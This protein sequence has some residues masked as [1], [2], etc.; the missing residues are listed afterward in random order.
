MKRVCVLFGGISSESAISLA[1]GQAILKA[2]ER[3]GYDAVPIK[4]T[5]NLESCIQSLTNPR[6]DVA[7]IGLHGK[8]AEDGIIQGV[9]EYLK[10]PY[11]G[12]G[13][14]ASALAMN[15]LKAKE[16]FAL[17]GIPI[18]KHVVVRRGDHKLSLP[19]PVVVK[20]NIE[21]SS[22]GISVVESESDYKVALEEAFRF[23]DTVLVEEYIPGVEI[24]IPVYLGESLEGI[25]ISPKS[26]FYDYKN[27]YTSGATD[28]FIPP[29]VSEDI[30]DNLR[31]L[32]LRAFE[33]LGCRQYGRV[34]FRVNGDKPYVLEVNTLPGCTET[35]LVPKA[36][37]Y[38]GIGFDEF[39][40]SLIETAR[41]DY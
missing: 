7:V 10:I 5:E 40:K 2:V 28:Y 11:T 25:E 20:P 9:L 27:K 14:L 19:V 30:R 12:S 16:M 29:R 41:C 37:S 17:H 34:D 32:A 8:Y 26:G 4:V 36:L 1:T 23:D 24:S 33:A 13:V 3:L 22:V 15:K 31:E 18:A 39:I 35:S 38:K 21:G 6:C